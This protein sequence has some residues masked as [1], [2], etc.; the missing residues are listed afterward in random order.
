M[1]ATSEDTGRRF[2]SN[3]ANNFV[4][5]A[6]GSISR[7]AVSILVARTLGPEGSGA[8]SVVLLVFTTLDL[9]T[10][11]GL[12]NLSARFVAEFHGACKWDFLADTIRYAIRRKMGAT[13]AVAVLLWFAAAPLAR[14]Y[15]DATLTGSFRLAAA[16]LLPYGISIVTTSIIQG[17]RSYRTLAIQSTISAVVTAILA[18]ILLRRL[19]FGIDAALLAMA[20]AAVMESGVYLSTVTLRGRVFWRSSR[21]MPRALRQRLQS[22]NVSVALIVLLDAI[23]WQKSEIFFLGRLSGATQTGFYSAAYGIAGWIVLFIPNVIMAVLFPTL[24]SLHGK[25]ESA[26]FDALYLRAVR[27]LILVSIPSA[28]FGIAV[29]RSLMVFVFGDAFAGAAIP[30]AILLAGNAFAVIG[31][32]ASSVVFAME[33]QK[34]VLRVAIWVAV[35]NLALDAVL[36]SVWD[37]SG[38][39]IAN[40]IARCAA[41]AAITGFVCRSRAV[42]FPWA[43]VA[44]TLVAAAPPTAAAILLTSVLAPLPAILAS[45]GLWLLAYPPLVVALGAIDAADQR[46]LENAMNRLPAGIRVPVVG[47]IHLLD[48]KAN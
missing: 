25:D 10:N 7:F 38:G 4:A 20:A 9:L 45:A 19:H 16:L 15:Q 21:V 12:Q 3:A 29:S 40:G 33:K 11:L 37:A 17:L 26:Q 27:F 18:W 5:T 34:L 44:R 13:A 41:V 28:L 8:Y 39:A 42:R 47:A 32:P 24:S 22:Y 1:P 14:F 35:A 43:L 31:S 48:R 36:I 2:A 23:V 6:A 30:L 46:M